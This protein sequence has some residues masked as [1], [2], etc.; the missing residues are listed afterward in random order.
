LPPNP[1]ISLLDVRQGADFDIERR[2]VADILGLITLPA[3]AEIAEASYRAAEWKAVAAT[4]KLAA[5]VRRQYWRAVAAREQNHA[6]TSARSAAEATSELAKRLG[7]TGALNKLDQSREHVFYAELS[8]QLARARTQ[9]AVEREKLT[10]AMGLWGTDIN[11]TIAAG[12]PPLPKKLGTPAGIEADALQ[13]HVEIKLARAELDATA[14]KFGLTQAT[15]LVNA[16]ELTAAENLSRSTTTDPATG[17]SSVDRTRMRGLELALEI[18]IFDFGETRKRE[19]QETYM[20]AANRLAAKAVNIRS[21]AR[22]AYVA[23]RGAWDTARLYQGQVLPLRKAIQEESLLHYNG[24]LTDLFVLIQDARARA[25]STSAAIDAKRDF[26][27]A[28]A[29]LRAA[30]IGGGGDGSSTDS[31][32]SAAPSSGGSD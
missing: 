11:Y 27:I 15:R 31:N 32:T 4:L 10:R 24:M 26:W 1:K 3:R 6:L 9:A 25:L 5:D 16:L 29:E 20:R 17:A 13:R 8:T 28:D 18:P 23:Y 7:E 2:F 12:L 19:A 30:I 21:M 22:Q 14:K